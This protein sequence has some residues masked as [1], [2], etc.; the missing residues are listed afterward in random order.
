M[1]ERLQL[2]EYLE[3][4]RLVQQCDQHQAQ[5]SGDGTDAFFTCV[6]QESQPVDGL[7]EPEE[8]HEP[9]V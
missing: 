9:Q 7:L 8:T 4:R 3:Q 6:A 5:E 2:A 1:V